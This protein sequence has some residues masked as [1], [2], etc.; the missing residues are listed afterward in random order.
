MIIYKENSSS[1]M[2][3]ILDRSINQIKFSLQVIIFQHFI[4]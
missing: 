4:K 3:Y 2:N 1:L